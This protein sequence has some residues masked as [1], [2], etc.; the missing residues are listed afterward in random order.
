MRFADLEV[1]FLRRHRKPA[2]SVGIGRVAVDGVWYFRVVSLPK[3]AGST[4]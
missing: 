2:R 4:V 3:A 1:Q